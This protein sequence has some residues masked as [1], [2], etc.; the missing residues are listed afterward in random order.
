[1]RKTRAPERE[2]APQ[3]H[4]S[5]RTAAARKARAQRAS[6]DPAA[7]CG[8]RGRAPLRARVLRKGGGL[9]IGQ[10]ALY[11]YRSIA[12][13]RTRVPL[14]IVYALV[15][16]PYMMDLEPDRSLIR[17][18]LVAGPGCVLDRLGL[19]G[20]RGSVHD[21]RGLSRRTAR[22]MRRGDL[23]SHGLDAL[24]LL[25]VC[26]GGVFSLCFAALHP[27]RVRNL[28]TMVTPVDFH[29]PRGSPVEVG[30]QNRCRCLGGQRKRLGRCAQSAVSCR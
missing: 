22:R 23:E 7:V 19:S 3:A 12:R 4:P 2:T 5:K 21:A 16:R 13:P 29:T 26:Q 24:N 1:M 8:S 14:L 6:D 28:I 9:A 25:G 10:A 27:E 17:G 20:R 30:A 18:L 11:R 15:N